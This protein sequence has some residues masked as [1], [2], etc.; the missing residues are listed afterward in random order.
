MEIKIRTDDTRVWVD[1]FDA[2]PGEQFYV[3]VRSKA[4]PPN[5]S[6]E[7]ISSGLH[8]GVGTDG[9]VHFWIPKDYM[10]PDLPREITANGGPL[11]S[12]VFTS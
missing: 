3:D 10:L 6:T 12:E 11:A 1:V 9:T 2:T 4:V 8:K 5:E 7:G